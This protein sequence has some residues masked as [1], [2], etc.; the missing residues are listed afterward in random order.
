MVSRKLNWWPSVNGANAALISELEKKI[1]LFYAEN[2]DYY[3]DIEFTSHNWIHSDEAG[4]KEIVAFAKRSNAI[5]EFGCG[6]ANILKHFPMLAS[7]YNGCDFSAKLMHENSIKYPGAGFS[8]IQEP[9]EL[10][11]ADRQ[12]DL[13]FSVFVLEHATRPSQLLSECNRILKPGGRLVILCPD[14]LG[15]GR[16]SSQ[17][18]GWSEGNTAQK[19]KAGKYIDAL[20]TFY[21]NRLR[22]PLHCKKL[23]K[24]ALVSP[25][26]YINISPTVF[27]DKFYPDVDAVY[28]TCKAEIEQYLSSD[29]EV[30][31]NSREIEDYENNKNLIFLSLIKR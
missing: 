5:C 26:F 6:S 16:M 1:A 13:V 10:P 17:R 15:K 30:D 8:Q 21:D 14:F 24:K 29:F 28:L 11:Y 25:Q 31:Q 9:N 23:Q 27:Q 7:K 19:I 3:S 4:Y 2:P 12:F 20:V 22:I 18:A